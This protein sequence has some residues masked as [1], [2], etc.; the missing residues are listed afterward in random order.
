[1]AGASNPA[2][3]ADRE[4][5]ISRVLDAPRAQVWR[6]VTDP[7]QVIRWWM[8]GPDGRACE[9]LITYLE[10][11]EPER[12]T[13]QQGGDKDSEPVGFQVTMTFEKEG[14]ADAKTRLTMRAVFPSTNARE[15]VIREHN[16]VEG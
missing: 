12:L 11:V 4:I 7:A 8:R 9:N 5:T 3:A 2:C 15:F 14:A 16:A 6:A 13:Y 1:M 10:V